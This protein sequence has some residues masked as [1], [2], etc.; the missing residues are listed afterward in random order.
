MKT[1]R[2]IL[3]CFFF[4][5]VVGG[6]WRYFM[7]SGDI[8]NN[9]STFPLLSKITSLV[10]RSS[11]KEDAKGDEDQPTDDDDDLPSKDDEVDPSDDNDTEFSDA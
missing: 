4:L 7:S 9:G 6:L 3:A 10:D 2:I 5:L 1:L 11:D 8:A